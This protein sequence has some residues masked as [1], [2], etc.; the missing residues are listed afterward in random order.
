MIAEGVLDGGEEVPDV[1]YD[2]LQVLT[3]LLVALL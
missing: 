1:V 2:V 3:F